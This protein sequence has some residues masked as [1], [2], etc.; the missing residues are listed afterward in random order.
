MENNT[1]KAFGLETNS[2]IEQVDTT[3][4]QPVVEEQPV[5]QEQPVQEQLDYSDTYI[6]EKEAETASFEDWRAEAEANE[7]TFSDKYRVYN[8]SASFWLDR[9][10]NDQYK[11]L[12]GGF[13]MNNEQFISAYNKATPEAR[14]EML[15]AETTGDALRIYDRN[16]R[17][18][19]SA[20]KMAND[21]MGEQLV[22]GFLYNVVLN[23]TNYIPFVAA[24]R[25]A[26]ITAS[27]LK[28]LNKLDKAIDS[29][30]YAKI[31]KGV[32]ASAA[33]G[34]AGAA[35]D[36]S[37]F[38]YQGLPH[39]YISSMTIGAALGGSLGALGAGLSTSLRRVAA[40][41]IVKDGDGYSVA[42]KEG[43]TDY[44]SD[45][46]DIIKKTNDKGY[47]EYFLLDRENMTER[48]IA[49]DDPR[50]MEAKA[51][52][53]ANLK[54]MKIDG[55]I[56]EFEYNK[57]VQE[58]GVKYRQYKNAENTRFKN[59]YDN[60]KEKFENKEN[61]KVNDWEEQY[62]KRLEV[63]K[64]NIKKQ[65]DRLKNIEEFTKRFENE[66]KAMKEMMGELSKEEKAKLPKG[67]MKENLKLA[68]EKNFGK[69]D[70]KIDKRTA[71]KRAEDFVKNKLG[72]K[73]ERKKFIDF[74]KFKKQNNM[75]LKE[76]P[77]FE[78][79][80]KDGK[81]IPDFEHPTELVPT[82]RRIN[83]PQSDGVPVIQSNGTVEMMQRND[84]AQKIWTD[85][86]P[87]L[88]KFLRS[89]QAILAQS[90]S[91]TARMFGALLVSAPEG[92]M[93]N[94]EVVRS[95]YSAYDYKR[96]LNGKSGTV[97]AIVQEEYR[98]LKSEGL[99]N[100]KI[101]D[102][103]VALDRFYQKAIKDQKEDLF[104]YITTERKIKEANG[105]KW[106]KK[107][108]EKASEEFFNN[109]KERL[110][111]DL[112][113][114]SSKAIREY[115]RLMDE[116]H[117]RA[118]GKRLSTNRNKLYAPR[119]L[120]AIAIS[121]LTDFEL[122]AKFQTAM[123]A[124]PFNSHLTDAQIKE[125]ADTYA[126]DLK[127]KESSK[128]S[129]V[130]DYMDNTGVEEAGRA[131]AREF[132]FDDTLLDDI[133]QQG[134]S[135]KVKMYSDRM[136]G[137]I[138]LKKFFKTSNVK[139]IETNISTMIYDKGEVLEKFEKEALNDLLLDIK[140]DLRIVKNGNSIA[141][142]IS[143]AMT[144]LSTVMY[145]P[146]FVFNQTIETASVI[147]FDS[148][149]G[150]LNGTF[151]K[152]VKDTL[153]T[154]ASG[155]FTDEQKFLIE[156]DIMHNALESIHMNRQVESDTGFPVNSFDEVLK[157]M[158]NTIF[159]YNGVRPMT[160][161]L[162]ITV[163][164]GLVRSIKD[165]SMKP[166]DFMRLG[167]DESS[168]K[169][170]GEELRTHHD[171]EGRSFKIENLSQDSRDAF[172]VAIA[173]GV[174]TLVVNPDSIYAPRFMK[175]P[176]PYVR[177]IFQFM[178]FPMI[179]NETLM[180]H[181]MNNEKIKVGIGV[182]LGS[183]IYTMQKY[184][185]EQ[186]YLNLGYIKE[187]DRKYDI[188]NNQEHAF[189]AFKTSLGYSALTGNFA[190]L[191]DYMASITGRPELGS[192]WKNGDLSN[193]LGVSLSTLEKIRIPLI[194]LSKGEELTKSD[195]MKL[196]SFIPLFNIP[197]VSKTFESFIK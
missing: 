6:Q 4:N 7:A 120:D 28:T 109:D 124:D 110:D 62:N 131:K 25:I 40:G 165:G 129:N 122:S 156:S 180:R 111:N 77:E 159:K 98:R 189:N 42:R 136:S 106:T 119:L 72:K 59:T 96:N 86:I 35:A 84:I 118:S 66:W 142:K 63:E 61:K 141:W 101:E 176:N 164:T 60:A 135:T 76:K 51:Q 112:F 179:A 114:N 1:T 137:D 178:R 127:Y 67:S 41:V 36:E 132:S 16:V 117:F 188:F 163:A 47:E 80:T 108:V 68:L 174:N 34:A 181:G 92:I 157:T 2:P 183:S 143:N 10:L 192:T 18:L 73:P 184:A 17:Y 152:G 175:I 99:F 30:K 113:G 190:S 191:Y 193:I 50:Y 196:K 8:S 31:A 23:P 186:T 81:E 182:A 154:M 26:K 172:Q 39:D 197:L 69:I 89:G 57:M 146:A 155:K 54:Q 56:D 125:R 158:A 97:I 115:Y 82:E 139:D 79:F 33:I 38:D 44:H 103:E 167:M 83:N 148:Y 87:G 151:A 107:D 94:G 105:E 185:L 85:R 170:L 140:G 195:Y 91:E 52:Y 144:G 53:E 5:V 65:E 55:Y 13:D 64:K 162:E 100:G 32:G 95:D 149:S 138:A 177:M 20:E 168:F 166:A 24:A 171:V 173:R 145:S 104:D 12:D 102:F 147:G 58:E 49:E 116:E 88:N 15:E 150:F 71:D 169:K 187:E 14:Q 27:S 90:K 9:D 128:D 29:V 126:R 130:Y 48:K 74:E 194:K 93:R 37:I 78:Q 161:M 11:D 160:N 123:K 121:K 70:K 3:N 134:A 46:N 75:V 22:D 19:Q 153:D 45:N 43:T 21:S 133:T